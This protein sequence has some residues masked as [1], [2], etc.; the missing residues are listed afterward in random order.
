MYTC[1]IGEEPYSYGY[2]GTGKSS[3][4]CMFSDFG[5]KFGKSDVIGAYLVS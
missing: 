5:K 2:G 3:V 1:F 4:D